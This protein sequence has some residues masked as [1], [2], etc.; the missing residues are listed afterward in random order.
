MDQLGAK[1]PFVRIKEAAKQGYSIKGY[2]SYRVIAPDGTVHSHRSPSNAVIEEL[3][4]DVTLAPKLPD[5]SRY[6]PLRKMW[7]KKQHDKLAK[8]LTKMLGQDKLDQDMRAVFEEQ[9][10][11]LEKRA[12]KQQDKVKKLAQG[13]DFFAAKA[14]LQKIQ[15][16]WA[17]FAAA[18]DAKA[19]LVAFT[20]DSAVKKEIAAGKALQKLQKKYDPSKLAQARKLKVALRKFAKKYAGTHAGTQAEQAINQ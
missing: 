20:K 18:G 17:G 11:A 12:G 14:K 5:E 10:A 16:E 19:Q 8:Y 3:L 6:A 15:K 9:Q 2:P 7:E 4:Q 13:P 1:Y